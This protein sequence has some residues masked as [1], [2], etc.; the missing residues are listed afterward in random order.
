[1]MHSEPTGGRKMSVNE[2]AAAT[3][4]EV[5]ASPEASP[6][7]AET[8]ASAEA[9]VLSQ[10]RGRLSSDGSWWWNGRRWV[11]ATSEDGSWRWDGNRWQA[12]VDLAGQRPEELAA[13]LARLAE[14]RYV[15]AGGTLASRT[16]EWQPEGDL[17]QLAERVREVGQ[18]L[19]YLDAGLTGEAGRS[20][21][22]RRR[23]QPGD[24]RQLEAE[25]DALSAEQRALT[26]RLGREAPEPS[27]KEADDILA[28]ARLLEERAALLR[29][30]LAEVDEVERMRTDAAVA[31]QKELA[32]AEKAR[33]EALQG[34]RR[35]VEAAE[36]AHT[37][38]LAEARA[39][40]RSILTPGG[41]ELKAGLG[42]L[43]LHARLLE[44]PV[45]RLAAAGL[46]AFTD[47][48]PELWLQHRETLAHLVLLESPEAESFPTALSEHSSALFL[49]IT[50]PTGAALWSCPAGQEKA[51]RQFAAAVSQHANQAAAAEQERER[52]ARRAENELDTISR[53]RSAIETAEAKLA[54]VESGSSLLSA[55]DDARLRLER[56]QGDTPELVEA[57]R[58]VLE[59]GRRLVAPPGPLLVG[60]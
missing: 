45:R 35:A 52:I 54:D 26:A 9:Q 44:T 48:A 46:T 38:A 41:G 27:I 23:S 3:T 20:I 56:A 42:V 30:G 59:L 12:T 29:A 60:T 49:L 24:R 7:A 37:R 10:V 14:D 43:R 15:R 1:M 4:Q 2:S 50:G 47:T 58:K 16:D 51:A 34:A 39:R 11:A 13:T 21:L 40:L 6:L 19:R 33:L 5:K 55:I 36:A 17:Q 57:R 53:D 25:R 31:A 28:S 8:A 32:A 18:R 22:G